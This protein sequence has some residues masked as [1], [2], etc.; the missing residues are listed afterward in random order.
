MY[1]GYTAGS[2]TYEYI[3]FIILFA[4]NPHNIIIVL[5]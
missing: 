1:R 3:I 5:E 4:M 2:Y